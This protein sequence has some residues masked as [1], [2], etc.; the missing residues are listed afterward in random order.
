MRVAIRFLGVIS[1]VILARLLDPTDFGLVAKATMIQSFLFLITELGLESALIR[2]QKTT[3]DHYNTVWTVHILRGVLIGSILAVLAHPASIY[4]HEPRLEYIIYCYAGV[5]FFEGFYNI[6]IV[7]FRKEMHFSNDFKY[8]LYKKLASF[9]VTLVVALIWKT[10]WALVAGVVANVLVSLFASFVMSKYRPK[11]SLCEWRSLFNFSKWLLGYEILGALS[12]KIDTFLLSRYSTT[13]AVGLYTIANEVAA[14]PSTEIAMPVA[15]AALP[16][17]SKLNHD[18]KQFSSMYLM[19]LSS[20]F[21][22]A[23]PATTG[24]CM[25]SDKITLTLLGAKW[26]DAIPYIQILAFFGLSRVVN[27]VATSAL[28]AFNRPDILTKVSVVRTILR[29]SV[30]GLGLYFFGVL[31]MVWGVLLVGFLGVII[32]MFI[33]NRLGMLPFNDLVGLIWRLVVSTLVMAGGLYVVHM[34]SFDVPMIFQLL[35]DV[36]WGAILY[37]VSLLFLWHFF[38]KGE[39][40]EN[41]VLQKFFK[42]RRTVTS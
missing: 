16:G 39:G 35:L 34:I 31:G 11:I 42:K 19:T 6:G 7:D 37:S 41:Y 24:V 21:L 13:A 28:V 5:T 33:Q 32:I 1:M 38:S 30:L 36:F 10:Y 27:A 12:S 15:R 40:P 9:T 3:N 29:L 26:V 23:I 22:I 14:T 8:N 18:L 25:L 2:D 4:L 20:V 17:L